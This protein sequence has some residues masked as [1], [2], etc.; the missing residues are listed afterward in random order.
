MANILITSKCNRN[1]SFCFAK[2]RLGRARSQTASPA[3][4]RSSLVPRVLDATDNA[5]PAMLGR[6]GER[7]PYAMNRASEP[8]MTWGNFIRVMDF[9]V[10]SDTRVLRLLGGEPT[11]HPEFERM[12]DYAVKAGFHVHVFTNGMMRAEIA[13]FLS[14]YASDQISALCNV[15]PQARDTERMLRRREYALEKLGSKVSVGITITSA[16]FDYDGLVDMIAR[17]QLK[18]RIRIG[19]AQPIVGEANEYL[20]PAEYRAVG[21]RLAE[22]ARECI[23]KDILIGF[24]CGLTLC[25]FSEEQIG[26]L[27]TC[28]EGFSCV[29]RPIIDIGPALDVWHCFPLSEVLNLQLDGSAT[30]SQIVRH[31]ERITHP[32]RVLGC[33]PQCL[34]C[35]H[36]RRGQCTGGCLAHAIN[37]LNKIP[38]RFCGNSPV[39]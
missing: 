32:F 12:V 8:D 4:G 21:A 14:S 27:A 34:K 39:S 10:R 30:R 9:L 31:Y 37:S 17:H 36:L 16:E 20:K 1:C 2:E 6:N 33:K 38:P 23:E 11:L 25:M 18:K 15:S 24:D 13:D 22:M 19:L 28:S 7:F 5:G 26:T 35:D 3:A 29:C